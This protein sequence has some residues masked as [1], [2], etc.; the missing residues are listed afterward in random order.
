[1]SLLHDFDLK[2]LKKA[3]TNAEV[4]AKK[5][6]GLRKSIDELRHYKTREAYLKDILN[7]I[8]KTIE[9]D[10]QPHL[11]AFNNKI[12]DLHIGAFV[13]PNPLDYISLTSGYNYNEEYDQSKVARTRNV[14]DHNIS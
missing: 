6:Q 1:M 3:T 8:A 12:Y 5:I 9:F 14:F 10:L 2:E 4:H 13:D 7:S 11:F